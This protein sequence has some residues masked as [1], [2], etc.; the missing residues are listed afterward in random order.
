[1]KDYPHFPAYELTCPCG[2]C[3]GGEMDDGFMFIIVCMRKQAGF[4]FPV[5]SGYR[6]PAYNQK[7]SST[8]PD[9]PHTTGHALDLGLYGEQAQ[10][11][12]GLAV[13]YG[14]TGIGL[15]QKGSYAERFIHLD[16]LEGGGDTP[17]PW[18]WTY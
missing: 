10:I 13:Q 1:M 2:E 16:D 6:C 8:G 7:V 9:G 18:V 3:D 17:R 4:P 5:T 14:L 12:L 15:N 11:V